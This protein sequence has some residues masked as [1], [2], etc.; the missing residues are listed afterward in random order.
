MLFKHALTR[1]QENYSCRCGAQ[2]G[3]VTQSIARKLHKKHK[4]NVP[5]DYE[6]SVPD[7]IERKCGVCPTWFTPSR[8]KPE[9]KYCSSE[10]RNIGNG[11]TTAAM[12]GD[13]MRDTGVGKTY[14]KM[15]G[16]HEHRIVMEQILGRPLTS[17]EVV[18]HKNGNK[19]D[20]RPENL[21]LM[22][23]SEHS[24]LHS[25]KKH[26]DC[27]VPSCVTRAKSRGLCGRHY[28][29]TRRH[30]TWLRFMRL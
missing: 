23:R 29:E 3:C 8:Y 27:N 12:R 20:N 9:A 21:E 2:Y 22:T 7:A 4:E 16:R 6:G 5:A 13:K 24:R 19:R 11:R 15:M 30:W 26:V 14:R 28:D 10:C 17:N 1:D 18:H 25:T